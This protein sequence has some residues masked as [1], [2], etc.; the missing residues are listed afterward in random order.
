VHHRVII[1]I[2]TASKTGTI[3]SAML[4]ME[5]QKD[6][7]K[8]VRTTVAATIRNEWQCPYP[9]SVFLLLGRRSSTRLLY[10]D[11]V[12]I[13]QDKELLFIKMGLTYDS[14]FSVSEAS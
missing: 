7:P 9:Y 12:L 5:G 13:I 1:S 8:T 3:K 4:I 6:T 11:E 2:Q 14:F 10:H